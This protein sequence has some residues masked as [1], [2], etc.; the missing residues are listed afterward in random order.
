LLLVV[1]DLGENPM[2]L[3]GRCGLYCGA[4]G[5]RQGK[6]KQ[7]VENLRKVTSTYGFDKAAPELAKWEPAFQHYKEY[8]EV[9]NGWVRMFGT[10]P[11]CIKGG[12]DPGCAVR[13]CSTQKGFVTCAECGEM[14]TCAKVKQYGPRAIEGLHKI[15][16]L[17]VDKW[18]SEMQKKVSA[19]YSYLGEKT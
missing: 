4:C 14:D 15:K 7:A 3:V 17:G 9:M 11:S 12:G 19:G 18:A 1:S 6:I 13:T 16:A 10:C 8:E 5:I 2:D